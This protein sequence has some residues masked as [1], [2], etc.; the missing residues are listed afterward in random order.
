M[1]VNYLV[2]FDKEKE[3]KEFDKD[4]TEI[5]KHKKYSKPYT[6]YDVTVPAR[7]HFK[8]FLYILGGIVMVALVIRFFVVRFQHKPEPITIT[9][10]VTVTGNTYNVTLDTKK[11]PAIGSLVYYYDS[12]ITV[13]KWAKLNQIRVDSD[14][15]TRFNI[16]KPNESE[17]TCLVEGDRSCPEWETCWEPWCKVWNEPPYTDCFDTSIIGETEQQLRDWICNND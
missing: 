5:L 11:L 13:Q 12:T 2:S 4:C 17:R 16:C 8:N 14:G 3:A 9:N 10:T 6:E 1:T 15:M 7:W